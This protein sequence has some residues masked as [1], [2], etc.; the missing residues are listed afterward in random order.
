MELFPLFFFSLLLRF[1][2]KNASQ[3]L[4]GCSTNCLINDFYPSKIYD[5]LKEATVRS[6]SLSPPAKI[7]FC[8]IY[9]QKKSLWNLMQLILFKNRLDLFYLSAKKKNASLSRLL[10]TNCS[11]SCVRYFRNLHYT[12]VTSASL[13]F[14]FFFL[15]IL[16]ISCF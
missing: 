2:C 4:S 5:F 6:K 16:I 12:F 1:L 7:H 10:I 13:L 11:K 14:F 15:I 3:F 8:F 9:C